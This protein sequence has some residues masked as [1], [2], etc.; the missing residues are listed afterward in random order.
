VLPPARLGRWL[1]RALVVVAGG[2]AGWGIAAGWHAA[3]SHAFLMSGALLVG[4]YAAQRQLSPGITFVGLVWIAS[5]LQR[6]SNPVG[7]P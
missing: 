4:Y 1:Q 3:P 2:F 7:L 6:F 5:W